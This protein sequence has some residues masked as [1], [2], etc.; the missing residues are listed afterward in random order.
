LLA[1]KW[2]ETK[3]A[4]WLPMVGVGVAWASILALP[5]AMLAGSIPARRMGVYMGVFNLFIVLPQI[6]MSFVVSRLY[7]TALGGDPLHVVMLGGA[8]LLVAA[9]ATTFV[10]YKPAPETKNA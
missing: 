1:T 6:V 10:S 8:V 9:A 5:Y 4:L 2:C 3:Y 7:Q